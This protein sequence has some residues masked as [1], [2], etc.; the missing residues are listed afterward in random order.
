M[1]KL[2][3]TVDFINDN[4]DVAGRRL[5]AEDIYRPGYLPKDPVRP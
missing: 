1:G 2:K 4:F 5:S 3:R